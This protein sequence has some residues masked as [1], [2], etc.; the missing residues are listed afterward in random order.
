MV[1]IAVVGGGFGGTYALRRLRHVRGLKLLLFEPREEFLFTPLLHEVA[2]GVLDYD[3]VTVSYKDLCPGI[4]HI[5]HEVRSIDLQKKTIYADKQYKFD[6][7]IIAPGAKT[8]FYGLE[9][10]LELKSFED[11]LRI[12]DTIEQN[13]RKAAKMLRQNKKADVSELLRMVIVGGGPTGVELAGE[14]VDLYNFRL[15]KERVESK[16]HITLVQGAPKLLPHLN[17]YFHKIA[18]RKLEEKGV[19]VI[20][21]ARVTNT[22]PLEIMQGKKKKVISANFVVWTAGI[23][24]NKI[25]I[26]ES[27]LTVE[28][29]LQIKEY[30]Y[31]FAVGD[32][33]KMSPALPALAQVASKQGKHAAENI[34]L[35]MKEKKPK[36]FRYRSRGMLISIGQKYGVGKIAGIPIKGFPAWFMMRTIYLFKFHNVRQE[37]RTAWE[38]TLRLFTR[39]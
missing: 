23:T 11:A 38:Y 1:R 16:P 5:K 30:P 24:P 28:K 15:T 32:S 29:T 35:L 21:N 19:E 3:A 22:A 12:R 7:I 33:A 2:G 13:V 34:I 17:K 27:D 18:S 31:A 10:T 9:K 36:S 39:E 6:Y 25:E 37:F 4:Q 14:C 20:L 8:N 26:P